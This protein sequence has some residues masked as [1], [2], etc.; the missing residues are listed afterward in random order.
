VNQ[1]L[2]LPVPM[3]SRAATAGAMAGQPP[4]TAGFSPQ[5]VTITAHVNA[6]FAL[7]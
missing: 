7:K 4:P 2:I 3:M 6:M 5:N 1:Q